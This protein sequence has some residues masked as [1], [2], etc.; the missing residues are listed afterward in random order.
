MSEEARELV[1]MVKDVY[2]QLSHAEKLQFVEHF[3]VIASEVMEA[4]PDMRAQYEDLRE[5]LRKAA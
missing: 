3:M 5:Q 1:E 2:P 4:Y